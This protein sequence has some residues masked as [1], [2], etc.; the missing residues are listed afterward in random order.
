[1]LVPQ[2]RA[3]ISFGLGA[4]GVQGLRRGTPIIAAVGFPF[5]GELPDLCRD[6]NV[7]KYLQHSAWVLNLAKAACVYDPEIFDLWPAGVDTEE[8]MELK[9]K[10]TIDV[11]IYIKF[12]FDRA[13]FEA[14]L[15]RPIRECLRAGN[16]TFTELTYRRYFP[17]EYKSALRRVKAM[18][19]LSAHES[20]GL[21][22][23]ECLSSNVPVIAWNQ[24]F[25]LDPIRFSYGLSVVEATS[26]PYFDERCGTTF[27]DITAFRQKFDAFMQDVESASFAPREFVLETVAIEKSTDRMIEIYRSL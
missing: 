26:V 19:F 5:P 6:H 9:E 3:V 7:R 10:K 22:Y 8:W 12:P 27:S 25:W 15:L 23:Q 24:G 1:M 20:Q 17:A 4:R 13:K 14:D 2:S 18:I 16:Y 11:L 21:A